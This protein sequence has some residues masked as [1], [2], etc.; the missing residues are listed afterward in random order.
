MAPT[1]RRGAGL[2][3]RCAVSGCGAAGAHG[4]PGRALL[5]GGAGE[6][7]RSK[8]RGP[9]NG[10]RAVTPPTWATAGSGHNTSLACCQVLAA[11]SG[12]VR[13]RE[14]MTW[15]VQQVHVPAVVLDEPV[16]L[17]RAAI[18]ETVERRTPII[19]ARKPW[20]SRNRSL[21][22][23]SPVVSSQRAPC[24]SALW[25]WLQAAYGERRVGVWGSRTS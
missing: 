23:R 17:E 18:S 12:M 25:V 22:T 19:L 14:W 1:G 15:T 24:C 4:S 9:H 16:G 7:R 13:Q 3:G 20:A 21:R 5:A 10:P 8:S 11:A 6:G 2:L